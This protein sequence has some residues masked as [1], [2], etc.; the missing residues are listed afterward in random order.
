MAYE[1]HRR[2]PGYPLYC[3]LYLVFTQD[4]QVFKES[5]QVPRRFSLTA[6]N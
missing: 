6:R 1:L 4:V 3:F 5:I 2:Y